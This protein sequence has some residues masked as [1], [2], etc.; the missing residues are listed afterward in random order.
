MDIRPDIAEALIA[1][2]KRQAAVSA[3]G[4]TV[5]SG[6]PGCLTLDGRINRDERIMVIEGALAGGP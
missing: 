4:L 3:Q 6:E 1:G 2:P 5:E